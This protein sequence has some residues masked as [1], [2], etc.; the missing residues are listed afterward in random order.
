[1]RGSFQVPLPTAKNR[2][3]YHEEEGGQ[4]VCGLVDHLTVPQSPCR[5]E[6]LDA[7][8]SRLEPF[9]RWRTQKW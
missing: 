7:K 1:M 6:W 3:M 8:H 5:E 9:S 4:A 2:L